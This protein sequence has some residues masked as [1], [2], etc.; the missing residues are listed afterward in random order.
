MT[1]DEILA[2]LKILEPW[3][4]RIDLGNGIFTKTESVMGEPVD[5]PRPTWE[6][7][8]QC[9]PADL[10]GKSVLDV[11]CNVDLE[12][13][14][15]SVYDLRPETIGRFGAHLLR[16]DEEE[17]NWDCGRAALPRDLA[18]GETTDLEFIFR[19]SKEPGDYI[20]EFDMVAE[21]ITWFEDFGAGVLRH[22]FT[23]G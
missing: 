14:C 1:R 16:G 19:A 23:V 8:Q 12:F 21:H 10:C 7:V 20:L 17:L 5:H 4:H 9:L 3:F 22:S 11:G 18:P 6:L 15:I 13:R 2:G